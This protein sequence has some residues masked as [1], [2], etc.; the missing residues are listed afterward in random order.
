MLSKEANE[1]LTRVGPGTPMGA[2]LRRSCHPVAT[3][4]ELDAEPL[5]N[6][7][8]LGEPLAV[9]RTDSGQ[10]EVDAEGHPQYLVQELG[11]LIWAY[12]G[13]APAPLLPRYDLFVR[14]DV[15]REVRITRLA[16]HWL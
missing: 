3:V 16:C 1:R 8:I 14:D 7:K 5:L 10:L 4:P 6:V 9:Y 11:G 2:R 12:L 15:E 13:P